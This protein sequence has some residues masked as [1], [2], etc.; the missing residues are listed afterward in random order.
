[1]FLSL[2][3]QQKMFLSLKN[4]LKGV[5]FTKNGCKM[6]GENGPSLSH[7]SFPP[8]WCGSLRKQES[9]L[10]GDC[11]TLGLAIHRQ[12]NLA[13]KTARGIAKTVENAPKMAAILETFYRSNELKIVSFKTWLKF[14]LETEDNLLNS[15]ILKL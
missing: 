15:H 13:H 10:V 5:R 9:S 4:T 3:N 11:V 14:L 12:L 2:R 6:V 8:F 1:M 7:L